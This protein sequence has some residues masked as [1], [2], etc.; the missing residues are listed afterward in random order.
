MT[1]CVELGTM[2]LSLADIR[3]QTFIDVFSF[4]IFFILTVII[5]IFDVWS[6]TLQP[7]PK[8]G[9]YIQKLT[10]SI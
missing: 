3:N 10:L 2:I 1:V 7:F 5:T 8:L 4:L 9:R 6:L